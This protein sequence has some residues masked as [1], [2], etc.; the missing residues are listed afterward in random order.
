MTPAPPPRPPR[1]AMPSRPAQTPAHPAL[2]LDF[3]KLKQ[4][5]LAVTAERYEILDAAGTPVLFA[6]RPSHALQNTGAA[7]AGA[8]GAI[9]VAAAFVWIGDKLPDTGA[10]LTT[11]FFVVAL[12]AIVSTFLYTVARLGKKRHV[13][14]YADESK[15][16]KIFEIKQDET[17]SG[18]TQ[19]FTV[20]DTGGRTLAVISK[21]ALTDILR[22]KWVVR[23]PSRARVLMIAK[24]DS[25]IRAILRRFLSQL[26]LLHFILCQG[27]SDVILGEL[28]KEMTLRDVYNLDLSKDRLRSVDRRI[29]LALAI[30]LDT[31]ERR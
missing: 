1:P 6:E 16:T 8:V 25:I 27:E 13:T 15:A 4:P 26:F 19:H 2:A 21:N 3:Y 7:L 10:F 5:F 29:A 23:D 30:L 12:A 17:V 9:A 28:K 20:V 24:E 11:L 18:L 14:C 22:K 31:G